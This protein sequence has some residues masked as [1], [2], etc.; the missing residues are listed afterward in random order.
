[1]GSGLCD[2][3][4]MRLDPRARS[5]Y[6]PPVREILLYPSHLCYWRCSHAIYNHFFSLQIYHYRHKGIMMYYVHVSFCFN[7]TRSNSLTQLLYS[8][9]LTG[10]IGALQNADI[11]ACKIQTGD[12]HMLLVK[13][14]F[15]L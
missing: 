13:I 7:F 14:N 9:I 3:S 4:K 12:M 6:L 2:E 10:D 1:M 15:D 5:V 8:E 11:S